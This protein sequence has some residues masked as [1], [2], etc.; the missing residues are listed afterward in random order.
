MR[1]DWNMTPLGSSLAMRSQI[2]MAEPPVFP[3]SSLV[4]PPSLALFFC[5]GEIT[6]TGSGYRAGFIV[7]LTVSY[8]LMLLRITGFSGQGPALAVFLFL[9]SSM[10][11][12]LLCSLTPSPP[13]SSLSAS[14]SCSF[15]V[16]ARWY[17]PSSFIS[18][19][20]FFNLFYVYF[21]LSPSFSILFPL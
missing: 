15:S 19:L 13:Y 17:F 12:S 18:L 1:A 4:L 16:T 5:D 11:L 10:S 14:V 6:H 3:P 9:S 2:K 7:L 21:T 8:V 20:L